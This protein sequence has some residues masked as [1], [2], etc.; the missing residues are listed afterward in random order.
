[1]NT[2]VDAP[3]AAGRQTMA[4]RGQVGLFALAF[5][6]R[7]AFVLVQQQRSLFFGGDYQGPDARLYDELGQSLAAGLGLSSPGPIGWKESGYPFAIGPTAW[8]M[9]GYPIVLAA[10]RMVFGESVLAIKLVHCALGAFACVFIA[11]IAS[12]LFGRAAGWIASVAAAVYYE[13]VFSVASLMSES[14]YTCLV[15]WMLWALVDAVTDGARSLSRFMKAGLLFGA[16][17]LVRP[18]AFGAAMLLASV[19]AIHA[20]PGTLRRAGQAA[21]FAAACLAALMPWAVRNARALDHFTLLSTQSGYVLWLGNNPGYDRLASDFSRFGGYSPAAAF[22]PLQETRGR[23]E[24]D[25]N[26]I[27]TQAAISHIISQPWRWIARMPH[28]LWN[29]WRPAEVTSSVR[30]Q[31]VA[32]TV[33]PALLIASVFG[34]MESRG[35]DASWPLRVFLVSNL[36]LHAAVT[37]EL[38]FRIPLWP[39]L[40]P[41]AAF[42]VTRVVDAWRFRLRGC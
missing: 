5:L 27:Y 12:V 24:I 10:V 42:G 40:M 37:G 41:F 38:R 1:M 25:V 28:K 14:L 20:A 3:A 33:Y 30:H 11:R 9:P 16:V 6:L 32:W 23:P 15:A 13:L 8:V 21:V 7:A 2:R 35:M 29:M 22:A 17:A 39:A 36:V 31:V 4:I 18:Q 19:M 34:L 26:R